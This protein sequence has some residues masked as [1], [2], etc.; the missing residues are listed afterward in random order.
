[1]VKGPQIQYKHE[2]GTIVVDETLAMEKAKTLWI[3]EWNLS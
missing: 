1:M 3:V 2:L